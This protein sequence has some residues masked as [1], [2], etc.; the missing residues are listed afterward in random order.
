M[1]QTLAKHNFRYKKKWGQ[2]FIFER[3]ILQRLVREAGIIPGDQVLEIGAGA[4]TLTRELLAQ[5]AEVLALEIDPTLLS[6]LNHSF[7]EEKVVFVSGDVLRHDLTALARQHGWQ[8]PYKVVANLPYYLTT[9]LIMKLLE[10]ETGIA[11]IVLMMQKEV[12]LRLAAQPSTKEY[13]AIT[14][15]VQYYARAELLFPV[16]RAVFQPIPQVDSQVV[17]LKPRENPPVPVGNKALFFKIVRAAF[18]QRRKVLLNSLL[19]VQPGMEKGFLREI[20]N[21]AGITP[22]LRGE[23]LSFAE[24][25]ALAHVWG[26]M[27]TE[28]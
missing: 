3:N 6:L 26:T 16:S 19:A 5:G 20:L 4:G 18:G 15:A 22:Q 21:R 28:K 2:N 1:R 23:N 13:G 27:H 24:F 8:G 17:R 25:A 9:P 10:K 12:A 11:D 14:L 7:P